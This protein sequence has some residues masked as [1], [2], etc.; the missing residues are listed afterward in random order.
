MDST[1]DERT[2]S[3]G[4]DALRG[5]R[6]SCACIASEEKVPPLVGCLRAGR[7]NVLA[8]DSRTAEALLA[9]TEE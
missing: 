6:Y 4:L 2:L 1:L 9:H 3:I 5:A 7:V 8:I